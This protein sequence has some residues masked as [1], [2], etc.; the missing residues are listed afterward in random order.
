M[1][2]V[3]TGGSRG[4]GL[5]VAQ[6]FAK[7]NIPVTLVSRSQAHLDAALARLPGSGHTAVAA[8]LGHGNPQLDWTGVTYLVNCAGISPA[9]LLV[10]MPDSA[11]EAT[12]ATNLTAPLKLLKQ[13]IKPLMANGKRNQVSPAIINVLSVLARPSYSMV[14]GTSVYVA[15]KAALAAFTEALAFELNGKVRV[16]CVLPG[17][18]DTDMGR[19]AGLNSPMV[20]MEQVSERIVEL[21]MGDENGVC[22]LIDVKP[23]AKTG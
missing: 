6:A 9:L 17:L 23:K 1:K 4:L 8:D 12:I 19:A 22:E 5:G 15:T 21:A 18:M 10:L 7:R 11:M 2:A 13:A 20:P 16:N 3:I 14:P